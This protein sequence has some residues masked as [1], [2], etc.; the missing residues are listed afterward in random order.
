[1]K[2]VFVTKHTCSQDMLLCVQGTNIIMKYINRTE[3]GQIIVVQ[4]IGAYSTLYNEALG[5]EC[6][7]R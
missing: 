3:D 2:R 7:T 6:P 4:L 1:M 5:L